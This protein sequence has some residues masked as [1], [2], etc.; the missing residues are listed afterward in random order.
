MKSFLDCWLYNFYIII[1]IVID[2]YFKTKAE[3]VQN[4]KQDK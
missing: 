3:K 1:I 4:E 2:L